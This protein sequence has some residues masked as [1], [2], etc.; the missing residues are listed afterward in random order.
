ML[1]VTP[2]QQE[3]LQVRGWPRVMLQVQRQATPLQGGWE[4]P[5]V[6]RQV[7]RQQQEML[8]VR[9]WPWVMLQVQR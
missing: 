3:M 1:Q 4:W 6:M 5:R 9:G 8:R 2:Q 7:T